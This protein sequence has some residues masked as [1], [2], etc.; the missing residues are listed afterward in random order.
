MGGLTEANLKALACPR[1]VERKRGYLGAVSGIDVGDGWVTAVV[2][3]TERQEVKLTLDGQGEPANVTACTGW[4]ATPASTW[5][6]SAL[7][8]LAQRESLQLQRKVDQG[9]CGPSTPGGPLFP[10]A[11]CSF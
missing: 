10:S 11:S 5:S 7:T 2:H 6:P 3:G 1:S 8:V 4:R 9:P